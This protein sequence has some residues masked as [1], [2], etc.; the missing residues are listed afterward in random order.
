MGN[1]CRDCRH[2][3]RESEGWEYPHIWWWECR[4]RPAMENLRSFP[5]KDTKCASFEASRKAKEGRGDGV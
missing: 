1:S 3:R 2:L 5:F 4:A